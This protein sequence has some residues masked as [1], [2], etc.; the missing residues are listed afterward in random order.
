MLTIFTMLTGMKKVPLLRINQN[1]ESLSE[2]FEVYVDIK[3]PKVAYADEVLILGI[4]TSLTGST[5]GRHLGH[6]NFHVPLLKI[7]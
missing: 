5:H 6:E 1:S 2:Y 7:K 3:M 4:S